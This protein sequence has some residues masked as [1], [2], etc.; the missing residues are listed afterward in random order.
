MRR[1]WDIARLGAI[2]IG[3]LLGIWSHILW[4]SFTHPWGWFASS[5][6]ALHT[7]YASIGSYDVYGFK[8]AQHASTLIGLAV[9][10][11]SLMRWARGCA[12]GEPFVLDRTRRRAWIAIAGG[13]LAAGC[14]STLINYPSYA[15]MLFYF[16]TTGTTAF[17]M[18]SVAAGF[19]LREQLAQSK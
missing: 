13:A 3:M 5:W 6:K 14:I 1:R 16:I 11:F 8:I 4:D 2:A 19:L 18:L 17:A 7:N 10:G 9:I 15:G 12:P